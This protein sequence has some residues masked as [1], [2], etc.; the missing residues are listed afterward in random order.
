MGRRDDWPLADLREAVRLYNKEAWTLERIGQRFGVT[1]ERARQVL[2]ACG[3]NTDGRHRTR[4]QRICKICGRGYSVL[5]SDRTF[6]SRGI[7]SQ[8]CWRPKLFVGVTC[9]ECGHK[10]RIPERRFKVNTSGLFFCNRICQGR[11]AGR[12]YGFTEHPEN[13]MVS[14]KSVKTILR[15]PAR[16]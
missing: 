15:R 10:M 5:K 14:V 6:R 3:V 7:C 12:H 1:K 16:A 11:Y 4:E 8:K 2:Q 9:S 13:R